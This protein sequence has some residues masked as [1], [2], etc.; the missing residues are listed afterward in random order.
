[1]NPTVAVAFTPAPAKQNP[2]LRQT[3]DAAALSVYYRAMF[4]TFASTRR[5]NPDVSLVLISDV[6]IPQPFFRLIEDLGVR[7][8]P[9]PFA[10]RPPPGFWPT[11]N[12][13]LYMLD[14]M[15]Y[16]AHSGDKPI[17]L[18]DPDIVCIRS[19]QSVFDRIDD[20]SILAY[21]TGFPVEERSQGI[22]AIEA[23][24]I[25]NA[26][27][28][29]LTS[30]PVHYGGEFYGFTPSGIAPVLARAEDAWRYGLKCW[31]NGERYLVTEEHLLNYALRRAS[32]R[33]AGMHVKRIWTAP[34]YR[35][36]SGDESDLALWHLP[37]EKDRGFKRL[38]ACASDQQ[39][40]F[41]RASEQ[42]FIGRVGVI[43]G[44]S[45]RRL[46][47]LAYDFGGNLARRA[48]RLVRGA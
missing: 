42:D 9:F 4:V 12:A 11:F 3:N 1:M 30:N 13:S 45:R 14:A 24:V 27:D 36:V 44:V 22:S 2:N 26:L 38:A 10:H 28:P 48:Q 15:N 23:S 34:T 19:L 33:D 32:V 17:L 39:S 18:L 46:G 37:S 25:H 8:Q 41:W 7:S 21:P 40:W 20:T 5:W 16:L 43:T 35:T 6:A 31:Q 29:T 47:R